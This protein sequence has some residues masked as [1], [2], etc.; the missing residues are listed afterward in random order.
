MSNSGI[1]IGA[2][3]SIRESVQDKVNS[4]PLDKLIGHP[5]MKTWQHLRE[6]ICK[7]AAQVRTTAFGGK[8]GHLVLVLDNAEYQTATTDP[9][10]TTD[11]LASPPHVHPELTPT[12]NQQERAQL[13]SAQRKKLTAYY[14]Q[15]A[16]DVAIVDRIVKEGIDPHYIATLNNK[17]TAY[18]N[19][20]IKSIL[21]HIKTEWVIIT[22]QDKT[23]AK[24]ALKEPWD[25]TSEITM[26]I[27][28]LNERVEYCHLLKMTDINDDSKVDVFIAS[29]YASEMFIDTEMN[30]W[31]KAHDKSWAAAQATFIALYKKK[32]VFN[33]QRANRRSGFDS[34]NSIAE[35]STASNHFTQHPPHQSLS[36]RLQL[37]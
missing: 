25:M 6:Q 35:R 3:I 34:A 5:T 33:N 22:N 9:T 30:D 23:D 28:E 21:H 15:E 4:L 14:L 26:F 20:T 24:E 31:E 1:G 8:H 16:T 37:A 13:E 11:R 10:L 19:E 36:S 18:T 29:M 7:I 27:E 32:R 17:Y 12:S 2:D